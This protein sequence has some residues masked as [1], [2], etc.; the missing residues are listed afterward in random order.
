MTGMSAVENE[1]MRTAPTSAGS[2]GSICSIF[3]DTC[4]RTT[5]SS[6]PQSNSSSK[7]APSALALAPSDL[8][9]GSVD[10]TSSTGLTISFSTWVGFELG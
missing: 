2:S 1:K 7:K 5:S 3:S 9:A 6:C 8:T 4:M 10:S